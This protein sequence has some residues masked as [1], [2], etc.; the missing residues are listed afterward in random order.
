M[1]TGK[2][3][4]GADL[5]I[6]HRS[7]HRCEPAHAVADQRD[8]ATI[9]TVQLSFVWCAQERQRGVNVLQRMGE[10][11]G[12]LAAKGAAVVEGHRVP[13]CAADGLRQVEVELVT[14]K[15]VQQQDGRVWT[16]ILR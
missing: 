3:S 7:H 9:D 5:R 4:H 16:R 6:V 10:R 12:P 13:A 8:A 14:R 15:A 11:I 1:T 2:G